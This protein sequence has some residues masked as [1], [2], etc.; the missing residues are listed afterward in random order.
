MAED[1]DAPD[2]ALRPDTPNE[3][4][5]DAWE[6]K[7]GQYLKN[8]GLLAASGLSDDLIAKLTQSMPHPGSEPADRG[9]KA[10]GEWD[11]EVDRVFALMDA[12]M[13]NADAIRLAAA[14]ADRPRHSVEEREHHI[15][16]RYWKRLEAER[17]LPRRG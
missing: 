3:R 17:H 12:G 16:Q 4:R 14:E 6:A 11:V 15:S 1:D 2:W 7:A 10:L 9:R 8:V 13:T 5:K